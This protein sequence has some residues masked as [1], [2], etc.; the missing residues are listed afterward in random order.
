MDATNGVPLIKVLERSDFDLAA[1][2]R[3]EGYV[4]VE[5]EQSPLPIRCPFSVANCV[6][7]IKAALAIRAPFAITPWQL[8]RHL[9][10]ERA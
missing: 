6:G 7:L 1:F 2:Y 8:Y 10:K 5:T 4:V 3:E 9:L